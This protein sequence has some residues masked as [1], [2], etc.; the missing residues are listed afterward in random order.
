MFEGKHV[1]KYQNRPFWL[2]RYLHLL[3]EFTY[4]I[5]WN[6]WQKWMIL[7]EQ[8][9]QQQQQLQQQQQQLQ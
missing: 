2:V 7:I 4:L 8:Q 1:N 9:Q 3:F 6:F 5:K